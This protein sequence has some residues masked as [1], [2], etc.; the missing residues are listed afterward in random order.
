MNEGASTSGVVKGVGLGLVGAITKP[1]SGA[2]ELVALAGQGLL[3]GAGWTSL[4]E[5]RQ[6]S[7]I[8]HTFSDANSRLKYGWKLIAGLGADHHTLLHVT[9]ARSMTASGSSVALVLTTWALFL[10]DTEQDKT[11]RVI[12]LAE[13][14]G[15]DHPSTPTLLCLRF[16]PALEM[17]ATSHARVVDFVRH[18]S[19]MVADTAH[20]DAQSEAESTLSD[21]PVLAESQ[22]STDTPLLFYVNQQSRNY[23]LSI[24]ALAKRQSE[25]RGFSVL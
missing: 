3:H 10:V 12:S 4:P 22:G 11:T 16:Q 18:S 14:S 7:I 8:E 5:V 17:E 23:F 13:L 2:A 15:L 1:L 25:G 19:G 20:D 6:Q 21:S 9:E 24:L